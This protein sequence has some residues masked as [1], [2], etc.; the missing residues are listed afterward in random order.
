MSAGYHKKKPPRP[1]LRRC[2]V[3]GSYQGEGAML[4]RRRAGEYAWYCVPCWGDFTAA[5]SAVQ[6][7]VARAA[8]RKAAVSARQKRPPNET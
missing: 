6:E 3:C 4:W 5:V 8:Q 1:P 7:A 2:S